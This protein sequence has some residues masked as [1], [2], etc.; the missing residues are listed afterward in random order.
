[1]NARAVMGRTAA[2][3]FAIFG[4]VILGMSA[5]QPAA[6]QTTPGGSYLSSCS[7][8][9]FTDGVLTANC[10]RPDGSIRTTSL[11]Q[12]ERCRAGVKNNSGKLECDT[13]TV[14]P[15]IPGG[16]YGTSCTDTRMA[17]GVLTGVCR[18]ADGNARV[19]SLSNAFGCIGGVDNSDGRLSC[20]AV[21]RAKFEGSCG[22]KAAIVIRVGGRP[23]DVIVF[24][25]DYGEKVHFVLP[26]GSSFATV[27]KGVEQ[28]GG[29]YSPVEFE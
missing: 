4:A 25:L 9:I 27:C 29:A 21:H 26:G 7:S 2:M 8:V 16:T 5:P 11:A 1:M 14:S 17:D 3:G 28:N 18:T 6:A 22:E 10:R 23:N 19:T 15:D 12:P 24:A 13:A 20:A